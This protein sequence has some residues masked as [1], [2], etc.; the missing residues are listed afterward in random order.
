VLHNGNTAVRWGLLLETLIEGSCGAPINLLE[1]ER[2]PPWLHFQNL[3]IRGLAFAFTQIH[4]AAAQGE[5]PQMAA[6]AA[7][8]MNDKAAT[9]L[10]QMIGFSPTARPRL[11]PRLANFVNFIGEGRAVGRLPRPWW[12]RN[13][14]ST[15]SRKS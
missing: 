7:K 4:N 14:K 9:Q 12:R 13:R 10:H 1:R 6:G 2:K 15:R 8:T 5:N 11:N 3:W